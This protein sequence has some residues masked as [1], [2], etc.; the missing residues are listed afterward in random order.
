M[1]MQISSSCT[2]HNYKVTIISPWSH[3]IRK[4][5]NP[6]TDKILSVNLNLKFNKSDSKEWY[7]KLFVVKMPEAKSTKISFIKKKKKK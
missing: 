5:K 2:T 7:A 6:E 1:H 4:H 3:L